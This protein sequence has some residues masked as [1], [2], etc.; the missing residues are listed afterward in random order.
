LKCWKSQD[1][2]EQAWVGG[3]ASTICW[4]DVRRLGG[5]DS[6]GKTTFRKD[7]LQSALWF[8]RRVKILSEVCFR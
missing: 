2:M 1:E 6:G 8:H 4:Y 7:W 3:V 5:V